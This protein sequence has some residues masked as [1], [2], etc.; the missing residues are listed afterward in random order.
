[1]CQEY[2]VEKDKNESHILELVD[3][4]LKKMGLEGGEAVK[5]I[6]RKSAEKKP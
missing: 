2:A 1:M 6:E 4:E 5:S 3:E